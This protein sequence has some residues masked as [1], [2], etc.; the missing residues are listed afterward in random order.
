MSAGPVSFGAKEAGE[1]I[2]KSENWMKT[3]ARAGKIPY[4]RLGRSMRWTPDHLAEI[5]RAR[6]QR[7]VPA[8]LPS[9]RSTGKRKNDGDVPL[10]QAKPPKRKPEA[11]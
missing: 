6:E 4:I 8:A 9:P 11:A 1:I 2:G 10:L 3:Q 5:L 7:P